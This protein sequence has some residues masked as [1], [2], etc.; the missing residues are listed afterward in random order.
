MS[1]PYKIPVSALIVVYDQSLHV[2]LLERADFPAHWQSVT[3]SQDPGETPYETATRELREETAIDA[4]QFGGVIDW[5]LA[6]V[7]EIF[8]QWRHRYPPGT[9]HN[10]EHVFGLRVPESLP[11]TIAPKEHLSSCWL[12]WRDAADKCFSWSNREAILRLPSREG[13]DG[14]DVA[15]RAIALTRQ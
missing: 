14:G 6:N 5:R 15:H 12:P 4:A 3:G 11:V 8:A 1:K 13:L 9:T 2:L 7:Y 10:I